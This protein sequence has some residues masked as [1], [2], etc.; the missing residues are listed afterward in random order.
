MAY[1]HK[2]LEYHED[3]TEKHEITEAERE[4]LRELQKE[5]NT[6]DDCG[7]ALRY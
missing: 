5:L 4:F 3:T 1:Y 6:Q 7:Q 2:N